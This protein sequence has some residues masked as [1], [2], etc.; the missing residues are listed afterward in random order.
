M[1]KV[2]L[3]YSGGLDTS[4]IIPWL[5]ENY[6][7]EVIA[8]AADLGQGEELEPLNEKAIKTG[9]SKLY[10][11]D[12][13]KEFVTDFIYPTLKAGAVYEGKYLLGTSFARPLIARRLVEIAEK[14]GAVA[15]A[16]GATGKG[17]DQVRFELSV[18]ALNPDLEIIAPWRLWDIKSRDDA[19]DYA[20]ERGIPVPVTKDR[21]YSMDRNLWHLS[22]EGGD[23]EDPWNEPKRD[24]YLLGV[25][26]ED[27]PDKPEYL[28]LEFEQGIPVSLNGEKLDPVKF[29]ETLNEL[30]GKHGIGIVDMVEN[31]LVGMKS[32]GVYETPGGTILYTAHQ[33]LEHLTL[34][35]LTLHYKEQIALK[36]AELVYDGVWYSPLREALDA[37]V[38][39][40]QKNVTGTVRLKLYKGNCSLAGTKSPYSLYSE[41]FATFGRDGV[42][43]QKDAEGFINLFGLPL[44][45]RA[46]MEKKSGLK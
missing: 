13:K 12:L 41:E 9:A 25:S 35:R 36:Y 34:D 20:K 14:E 26:P 3:A 2:V 44:K 11:E 15:I 16:H 40:T 10:I 19:M 28:E 31:R 33:A 21:P 18:K 27:A 6:G 37:F 30:G 23:L 29:L 17:N 22:H 43:N 39:V 32:R 8:M 45:V 38:D 7:Y 4:I 42:Y 24:L 46:L 5:K 1:K